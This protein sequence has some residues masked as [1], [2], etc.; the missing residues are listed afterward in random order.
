MKKGNEKKKDRVINYETKKKN[1][2][3]GYV[4]WPD[5]E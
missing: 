5:L 3:Y 4:K 1:K 2:K